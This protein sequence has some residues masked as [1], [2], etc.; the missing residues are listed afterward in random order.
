MELEFIATAVPAEGWRTYGT[1]FGCP[2]E[3]GSEDAAFFDVLPLLPLL[4]LETECH[5]GDLPLVGTI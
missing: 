4:V 2:D 5:A 3:S 1:T